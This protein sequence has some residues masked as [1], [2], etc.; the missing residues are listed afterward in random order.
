MIEQIKS[1]KHT[2]EL[3]EQE[4]Q[5]NLH[6]I[7]KKVLQD[8]SQLKKE[9]LQKVH[10]AVTNF[11]KVADQQMAEVRSASIILKGSIY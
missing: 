6:S 8:K 1:L 11:R 10:E 4:Y 2:L 5:E 9:M 3:K 7:E